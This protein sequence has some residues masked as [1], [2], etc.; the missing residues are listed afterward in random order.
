M[1]MY[2]R[3]FN[4][5]HYFHHVRGERE[6]SSM[7][8]LG[9]YPAAHFLNS[10]A[11]SPIIAYALVTVKGVVG[12]LNQMEQTQALVRRPHVVVATPGR[13]LDIVRTTDDVQRAVQRM[14]TLVLDE[15]DRLLSGTLVEEIKDMV[16]TLNSIRG[17]RAPKLKVSSLRL[18]LC[19]G[20]SFVL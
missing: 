11:P 5:V 15:A 4:I 20:C 13:F 18:P 7:H 8:T 2:Q 14:R 3:W 9:G 17:S 12:G 6:T 1:Y 19:S 16:E 10:I